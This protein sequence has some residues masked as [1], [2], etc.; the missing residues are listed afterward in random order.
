LKQARGRSRDRL[1]SLG[2]FGGTILFDIVKSTHNKAFERAPVF[3]LRRARVRRAAH[4][5]V[6]AAN[7]SERSFE[8]QPNGVRAFSVV[9]FEGRANEATQLKITIPLKCPT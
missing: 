6:S 4:A 5:H 8:N 7:R 9:A 1:L 3:G 2:L